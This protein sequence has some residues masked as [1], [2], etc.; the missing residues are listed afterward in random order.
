MIIPVRCF[1]CNKVLASKYQKYLENTQI[2]ESKDNEVITNLN[3]LDD[4]SKKVEHNKTI[5]ESLGIDRYCCKRHLLTH[6]D[7][8][9]KI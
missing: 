2:Y 5:F 3:D 1:T 6:V 9:Q 4:V 7:L 8:I